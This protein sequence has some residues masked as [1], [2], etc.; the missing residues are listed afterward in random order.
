MT[1]AEDFPGSGSSKINTSR[2]CRR[3]E[4]FMTVLRMASGTFNAYDLFD[5]D[6]PYVASVDR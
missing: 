4:Y 6:A 3:D 1:W 5:R 2:F